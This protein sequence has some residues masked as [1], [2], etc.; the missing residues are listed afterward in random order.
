MSKWLFIP[1]IFSVYFFAFQLRLCR[2]RLTSSNGYL[3]VIF[4][5]LD[6]FSVVFAIVFVEVKVG[7]HMG[8]IL[9]VSAMYMY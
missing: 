9:S 1:N 5:A 7:T 4:Y 6:V 3:E 8:A 2:K